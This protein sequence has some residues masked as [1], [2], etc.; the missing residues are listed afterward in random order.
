MSKFTSYYG[1]IT[2]E[3]ASS[4]SNHIRHQ[5]QPN[6]IDIEISIF[7]H[8]LYI[9]NTTPKFTKSKFNFHKLINYVFSIFYS[10]LFILEL[11]ETQSDSPTQTSRHTIVRQEICIFSKF[12]NTIRESLTSNE[13]S[14]SVK[15]DLQKILAWFI[16]DNFAHN[17]DLISLARKK[18][19]PQNSDNETVLADETDYV[20]DPDRSQLLF[21]NIPNDI[22]SQATTTFSIN[23]DYVRISPLTIVATSLNYNALFTDRTGNNS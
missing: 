4:K 1:K 8:R 19:R 9:N 16:I 14:Q 11:R 15:H 17:I 2:I 12:S 22:S 5:K 18:F 20:W 6:D 3:I 21:I 13:I 7:F 10:Y 23:R